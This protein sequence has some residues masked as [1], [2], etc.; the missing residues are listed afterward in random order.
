MQDTDPQIHFS[1]KLPGAGTLVLKSIGSFSMAGARSTSAASAW[2]A[3]AAATAGI[4][5]ET[6]GKER[7]VLRSNDLRSKATYPF[8]Y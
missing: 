7:N 3:I 4:T 5:T 1:G 6:T 2:G 8:P